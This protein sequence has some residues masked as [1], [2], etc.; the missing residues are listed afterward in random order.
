MTTQEKLIETDHEA[1]KPLIAAAERLMEMRSERASLG[2]KIK[3][4]AEAVKAIMHD[5]D[6]EV[7][8]H[9]DM[10]VRLRPGA[11]K[12]IVESHGKVSEPEEVDDEAE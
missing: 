7:Y 8:T 10:T 9:G 12:V 1:D 5:R 3:D 2:T 4:A 6:L 11:E